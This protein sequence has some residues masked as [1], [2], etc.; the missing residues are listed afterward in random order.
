[1][2]PGTRVAALTVL[3]C[4]RVCMRRGAW[5]G[6]ANIV[7]GPFSL[8]LAEGASLGNRNIVSGARRPR[9]GEAAAC[10]WIER[11]GRIT[12]SHAIDVTRSIRIGVHAIVAGKG[13]QIWTHGYI[14]ARVGPDRARIDGRVSI[15]DNTYIGAMSCISPGVSIG[16]GITVGGHA[17]VARD[18]LEPG[19]Y[20][21]AP[22]R[23]IEGD[24]YARR[25]RHGPPVPDSLD[26]DVRVRR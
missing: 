6:A 23:H 24:P 12:S 13:S 21:S 25:D 19:V 9:P 18:L 14:H 7:R 4:P 2:G 22:L 8:F 17:S 10:L 15:G 20:V 16:A 5:I 3:S 26:G 11:G 1:M